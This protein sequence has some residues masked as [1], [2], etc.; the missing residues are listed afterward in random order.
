MSKK[1][2]FERIGGGT[3]G[4]YRRKPKSFWDQVGGVLGGIVLMA[5]VV[6]LVGAVIA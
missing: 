2:E 5:I 4:V 3:Y 1:A 6:G